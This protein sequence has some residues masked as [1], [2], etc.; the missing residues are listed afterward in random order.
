MRLICTETLELEEVASHEEVS[1][2]ILSHTWEDGEVSLQDLRDLPSARQKKGFSKIENTCKIARG[3]GIQYAWVDTCC[4]DK[5]SSAELSEAINS[6]YRWYHDALVCFAYLPDMPV[7]DTFAGDASSEALGRAFRA[8]NWFTRGWTLQELIAPKNLEFYNEAWSQFGTKE[9]LD[10]LLE[11]ITRIPR[12]IL[13]HEATLDSI[14]VGRR[15]SWASRRR[16]TRT[17]DLAYCLMGLFDINM[18][19]LY[20]EGPKAF[21]RLQEEI[22]R[23]SNDLSLLAWEPQERQ[24]RRQDLYGAFAPSPSEFERCGK[25]CRN[26]GWMRNQNEVAVTSRG[27][28]LERALLT[29]SNAGLYLIL[30]CALEATPNVEPV[31]VKVL[32]SPDGYYKVPPLGFGWVHLSETYRETIYVRKTVSPEDTE[33]SLTAKDI[34]ILQFTLH[35]PLTP[36]DIIEAFPPETWIA[37]S[38]RFL[39][40]E[41][42]QITCLRISLDCV[43]PGLVLAL[44]FHSTDISDTVS[45]EAGFAD[46]ENL[47]MAETWALS[48]RKQPAAYAPFKPLD[49]ITVLLIPETNIRVHIT[50]RVNERNLHIDLVGMKPPVHDEVTFPDSCDFGRS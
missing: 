7:G 14:A 6:M 29:R 8:C 31:G 48:V 36:G 18:P 40:H 3:Q 21:I 1:Y 30:D 22:F 20:G 16:T 24:L 25:L 33:K 26:R 10:F 37:H 45:M 41:G 2:A 50:E 44:T 49:P 28:R 27:V 39:Y 4:I 13:M 38:L 42:E 17:E 46:R 9:S 47:M 34:H 43:R 32:Q 35:E 11:A 23:Q 15:M 5:S 19:M 12:R